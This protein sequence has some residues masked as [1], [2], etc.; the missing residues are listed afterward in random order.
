MSISLVY[1]INKLTIEPKLH[2]KFLNIFVIRRNKYKY[3]VRGNILRWIITLSLFIVVGPAFS[4]PDNIDCQN[5]F[6]IT[7][8]IAWCSEPTEF[9]NVDAPGSG[10]GPATCWINGNNDVWFK[11]TAFAK[12]INVVINGSGFQGTLDNPE[13]AIYAGVCGGTIMMN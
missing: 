4:Q 3:M 6:V 8:P 9:T 11:F 12:A 7:D 1:F 13:I 2:A 10:Y 5:A